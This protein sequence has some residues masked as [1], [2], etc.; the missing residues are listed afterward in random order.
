MKYVL[1]VA[2][3]MAGFYIAMTQ[4]ALTAVQSITPYYEHADEIAQQVAKR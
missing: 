3:M 4:L 1:V 2:L